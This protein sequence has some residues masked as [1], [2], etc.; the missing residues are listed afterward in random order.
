MV[1]EPLKIM[2]P[3]NIILIIII[4]KMILKGFLYLQHIESRLKFHKENMITW[5]SSEKKNNKVKFYNKARCSIEKIQ[6]KFFD[7]KITL[8]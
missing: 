8:A 6:K 5:I 3:F 2:K 7:K 1:K 4:I